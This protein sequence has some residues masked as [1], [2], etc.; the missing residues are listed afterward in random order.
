MAASVPDPPVSITNNADITNAVQI[1][2]T[3][4]PG[5]SSGGSPVIDF[6]ISYHEGTGTFVTLEEGVSAYSYTATGLTGGSTY[7]FKIEARNSVGYGTYSDEVVVVCAGIPDPPILSNNAA[8]TTDSQI[9]MQWVDGSSNGGL[10][11][12]EYRLWFD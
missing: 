6:R 7:T 1:G 5:S 4:S 11:I 2:L 8:Q 3:W 12:S 9:S 10:A